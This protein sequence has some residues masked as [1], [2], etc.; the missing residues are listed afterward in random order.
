MLHGRQNSMEIPDIVLRDGG[1]LNGN[2]TENELQ[3][4][5]DFSKVVLLLSSFSSTISYLLFYV[6][7]GKLYCWPHMKNVIQD[8][9]DEKL[10]I[11][12]NIKSKWNPANKDKPRNEKPLHATI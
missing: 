8:N 4:F 2:N 10:N 7:W 3:E 11:W 9:H 5:E 12:L 6:V 1:K